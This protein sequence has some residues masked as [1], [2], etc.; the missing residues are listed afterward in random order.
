MKIINEITANIVKNAKDGESIHSLA[1]KI[2]FAY[3][4]VYKWV[5]VLEEYKVMNLVR[6]GNK[7]VIKINRNLIYKKFREL[8]DAISVIEKDRIFW[9]LVKNLK[10]KIRFTKGTAIVIWTQG[11]YITGDFADRIYFLEVYKR[12]INSLKKILK[13]HDIDH[14]EKQIINKRPLIFIIPKKDFKISKKN[15]LPIMPLNE[16]I[17]WCKKLHLNNV[18]EQLDSLYNLKLKVKYSE[19]YTNF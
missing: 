16:L 8:D 5:C 13:K 12:D 10:L 7:N 3:S 1:R 15:S 11:S 4:A 18:L 2:G 19:I 6:K 9:N 14:T 17:K